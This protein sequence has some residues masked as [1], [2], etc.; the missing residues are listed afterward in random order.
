MDYLISVVA[1]I[2]SISLAIHSRFAIWKEPQSAPMLPLG[3]GYTVNSTD[4]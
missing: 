3:Y 4:K 2:Y 1:K